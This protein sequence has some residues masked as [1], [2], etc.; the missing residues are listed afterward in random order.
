[1][2]GNKGPDQNQLFYAF[3][4]EDRVPKDHLLRGIDQFLDLSDLCDHLAPYYSHTG[5]PSIDPELMIRMLLIGYCFGIRSERR[6]CEEVELN[7]AYRWFCR[8]SIE[9]TVPDH[10]TFSKNRHGRFRDAQTFRYVFEQVLHRC[11][12]GG[13][14]RGEGFATDASIVKADASRQQHHEGDDDDDWSDPSRAVN[15]YL[16]SLDRS[17][18]PGGQPAKKISR[19]DPASRWTAAPG[20]PA[21]YGYS[22]NYLIDVQ[23]GIIVDV[24]A[25]PTNRVF[26]VESSMTMMQ[27]VED[28]FNLKPSTFMGDTAYGSAKMLGW[29]VEEKQITPHVPVHDKSEGKATLFGRSDFTWEPD[30]DRYQCP[31]GQ[32]LVRNLRTFTKPRTGVTKAN[33]IIY[34]ARE[35]E[36]ARCSKKDQC[37]PKTP[38]RKIHR[39]IHEDARDVARQQATTNAYAQSRRDRKKVEMLFAHMKRILKLDRLRLR[40][41][42]GAS[43]E[44]VLAATAQ[45]LRRMAQWLGKGPPTG[46]NAGAA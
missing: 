7:L 16:G 32:I 36:C 45:N 2:M 20:G 38:A 10:S 1:M 19:T 4:L 41:P 31:D 27:R 14:V 11:I 43:D 28:R 21:F 42:T 39:S 18:P 24:E 34:R 35:V 37:C 23:A 12:K 3:N 6:L 25:T 22:T 8:L 30:E 5:R 15:E 33:T 29:L 13:L 26:E 44:F 17:I 9:D 40:G 46:I